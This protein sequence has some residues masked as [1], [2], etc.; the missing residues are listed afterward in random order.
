M[1]TI[2]LDVL[3]QGEWYVILV[4]AHGPNNLHSDGTKFILLLWFSDHCTWLYLSKFWLKRRSKYIWLYMVHQMLCMMCAHLCLPMHV[5]FFLK[6]YLWSMT[7]FEEILVCDFQTSVYLPLSIWFY[8]FLWR[9]L[10]MLDLWGVAYYVCMVHACI[11][12]ENFNFS[13]NF[14]VH[15]LC[16]YV[17]WVSPCAWCDSQ[18]YNIMFLLVY[19]NLFFLLCESFFLS[20]SVR[21]ISAAESLWCANT[22]LLV[23]HG[24]LKRLF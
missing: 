14:C 24:W 4:C 3:L 23:S 20:K 10:K 22:S 8:V 5:Y 21:L 12:F 19:R 15:D 2:L 6:T 18:R 1:K 16:L 7:I 9:L 13:A 17:L 11:C